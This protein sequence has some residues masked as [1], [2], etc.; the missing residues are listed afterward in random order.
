MK[1]TRVLPFLKTRVEGPVAFS[2]YG[3][4]VG[5]YEQA[6]ERSLAMSLLILL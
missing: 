1:G 2:I 6:P 4:S 3:K 5:S